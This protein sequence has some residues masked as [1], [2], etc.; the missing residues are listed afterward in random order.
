ML[1]LAEEAV[2]YLQRRPRKHEDKRL[3]VVSISLASRICA[4]VFRWRRNQRKV[5]RVKASRRRDEKQ[6]LDTE[7]LSIMYGYFHKRYAR[8]CDWD[9]ANSFIAA[10]ALRML[11]FP[12]KCAHGR[13]NV[14]GCRTC[15]RWCKDIAIYDT[16][17][18]LQWPV[19][20]AWP[21]PLGRMLVQG[22]GGEATLM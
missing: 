1:Q 17:D 15:M 11:D 7:E 6:R 21:D 3:Y 9:H 20:F 2:V 16:P 18:A 12:S 5:G 13:R 8:V 19:P 14:F 22:D 4:F 10:F